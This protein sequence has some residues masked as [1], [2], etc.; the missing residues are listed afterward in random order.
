MPPGNTKAS[1][2]LTGTGNLGQ[3]FIREQALRAVQLPNI[4]TDPVSPVGSGRPASGPYELRV[5]YRLMVRGP[6]AGR[7]VAAGCR[8]G[9]SDGL[10][11]CLSAWR[12][13]GSG[14]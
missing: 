11:G 7:A 13:V 5:P 12:D 1:S 14:S 6:S 4:M 2:H 10:G 3:F 9:H 8:A